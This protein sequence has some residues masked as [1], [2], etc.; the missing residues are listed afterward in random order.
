[1]NPYYDSEMK[2]RALKE[3]LEQVQEAHRDLDEAMDELKR[4]A[5]DFSE[6]SQQRFMAAM[7]DC[8]KVRDQVWYLE[9]RRKD[10]D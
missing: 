1:M 2:D 6:G 8:N 5:T 9:Q 3:Y 10:Y 4:V 7:R